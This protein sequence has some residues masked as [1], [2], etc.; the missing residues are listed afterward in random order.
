MLLPCCVQLCPHQGS[1]RPQCRFAGRA[2]RLCC[3]CRRLAAMQFLRLCL[4]PILPPREA[5]QPYQFQKDWRSKL[6]EMI[7]AF[8]HPPASHLFPVVI[9]VQ[10]FWVSV[11][12]I[13]RCTHARHALA[14]SK[15]LVPTQ[16]CEWLLLQSREQ[17]I[18]ARRT[19]PRPPAWPSV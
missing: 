9:R 16:H 19:P 17:P 3:R 14:C 11:I 18:T 13:C 15:A 2:A 8:Q 1:P 5:L 4:P 10:V 6:Q 12:C 7:P